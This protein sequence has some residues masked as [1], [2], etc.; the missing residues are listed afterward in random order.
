MGNLAVGPDPRRNLTVLATKQYRQ[1]LLAY[2]QTVGQVRRVVEAHLRY[3][4]RDVL[5][6][7]VSLC[8]S[9]MLANVGKHAG[10]PACVL[11]LEDTGVAVRLTVSD[12]SKTLP[13]VCQVDLCA[14]SGRGMRLIAASASSFGCTLTDVGKDVWALFLDNQG[15]AA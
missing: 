15:E 7:S 13:M 3:W 8:T 2:P 14:E 4:G 5:R 10:S 11:L 9:E 6:D 1:H 12:S